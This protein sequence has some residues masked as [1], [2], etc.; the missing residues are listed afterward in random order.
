MKK[1]IKS[2][3]NDTTLKN[4]SLLYAKITSF[5]RTVGIQVSKLFTVSKHLSSLFYTIT[6]EFNRQAF[7]SLKGRQ[8]YIKS[9]D[10]NCSLY[11]RNIHRLEKAMIMRPLRDKFA[12]DYINEL[13]QSHKKIKELVSDTQFL[14]GGQ[15]LQKYF[16]VV[17]K[18]KSTI[19]DKARN[20]F[21]ENLSIDNVYQELKDQNMP[22]P[23]TPFAYQNREQFK[24]DYDD[25][26]ALVKA[27]KSIRWFKNEPVDIKLLHKAA[28]VASQAPS[29]CNRQPFNFYFTNDA[30]KAQSI[31]SLAMGSAGFLKNIPS[32]IAV[33][34]D[35]SYFDCAH[36]R[37]VIYIDSSL[38]T[39][40]LL[41]AFETLGLSSCV[42]NWP[43]IKSRDEKLSKYLKL[44]SYQR[45]TCL[46]A[47]GYPE[48][49]GL[50]PYSE[51]KPSSELIKE[52]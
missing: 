52:I 14:W 25:L 16:S 38:A 7:A 17:L 11:R 23:K 51:K 10:L 15:V 32:I 50:T 6:G 19:I 31:A 12:E 22:I 1:M 42:L 30:Q 46:I 20:A 3:V 28:A 8:A 24:V 36:D 47:V 49:A 5:Q 26:F 44:E 29:A 13:V 33:V 43:D 39:M 4:L 40:Q 9:A 45:V 34:G 27:R 48:E 37:Q 41:L 35:L 18:G 21:F 2:L